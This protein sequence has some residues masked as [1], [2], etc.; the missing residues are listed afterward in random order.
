MT[1][2]SQWQIID[3]G[4]ASAKRNME[5]DTK[6][7]EELDGRP[8]L[9]LYDWEVSSVTYG[10]FIDPTL[11][12]SQ[13]AFACLELAKRPTG[14]GVIFHQSDWAFSALIPSS[15]HAYSM[16][17]MDNYAFINQIV[18]HSIRHFIGHQANL[19]LLP[20]ESKALDRHCENFCMA[21]PT[22]Y[23]VI[24][25]GKK[26]AGG[27]Q[28]RTR[29]GYLHQGSISLALPAK[30][31]LQTM[32]LPDTCVYQSMVENTCALLPGN[33]SSNDLLEARQLLCESFVS[34]IKEF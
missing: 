21:K 31:F 33:Y 19:S 34:V 16:N 23:D 20:N 2:N 17:T 9:H 7:L 28:R 18:I 27:A 29:A 25:D 5:L 14:G 1:L 15:Y 11:F 12:L 4:V 13:E 22:K 8:I 26:V 30:K 32:L 3:S 24:L 10:H 6:L